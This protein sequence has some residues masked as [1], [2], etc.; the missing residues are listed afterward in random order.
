MTNKEKFLA[1]VSGSEPETM[2]EVKERNRNRAMLE[3]SQDIALK[4]LMRLDE[5]GWSQKDLA[6]K[7][8]V[9]PQQ[10]NKIVKGQEN[11]TLATIVKLQDILNI[12]ILSS[13]DEKK[14]ETIEELSTDTFDSP[15]K[16]PM[17]KIINLFD[18]DR[19]SSEMHES[20]EVR[21]PAC[22][23]DSALSIANGEY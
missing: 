13:Y 16:L 20:K 4:V 21:E 15:M 10:V 14:N 17:A 6:A 3:E 1:L 22:T 2:A 18:Y 23:Y 5:L 12:G 8:E 9:S 7:L 11:L 19:S